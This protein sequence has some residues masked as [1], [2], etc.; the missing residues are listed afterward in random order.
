[1]NRR[2]EKRAGRRQP[3]RQPRP[4]PATDDGVSVAPL[5]ERHP[6]QSS[7]HAGSAPSAPDG[8]IGVTVGAANPL[9][10]YPSTCTN[11]AVP[12]LR[13]LAEEYRRRG[14]GCVTLYGRAVRVTHP[15]ASFGMES[16]TDD[17]TATS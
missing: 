17:G 15:L 5:L 2:G 14:D 4:L 12:P 11:P 16:R 10:L 7:K 13:E 3:G 1:M 8:L 9:P 6:Q